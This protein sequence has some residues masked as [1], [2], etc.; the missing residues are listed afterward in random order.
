M[1][2]I[3][4]LL[5]NLF[6]VNSLP[7]TNKI[8]N[9][10]NDTILINKKNINNAEG[11]ISI[12]KSQI[13]N[14]AYER[15]NI[16]NKI[17]YLDQTISIIIKQNNK[18]NESITNTTTEIQLITNNLN[19]ASI[20]QKS[21]QNTVQLHESKIDNINKNINIS[22]LNTISIRLN[23]VEA[24]ITD[25]KKNKNS[26]DKELLKTANDFLSKKYDN[27]FTAI[28]QQLFNI[29]NIFI[30]ISNRLEKIDN[31]IHVN[32]EPSDDK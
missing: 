28:E 17:T 19:T 1:K 6:L 7:Q 27:K 5:A 13:S 8:G 29:S 20:K 4:F 25:I 10:F 12:I 24:N 21:L 3:L 32:L 22:N 31:Y 11:N 9:K 2:I 23:N 30:K 15:S 14:E 18:I 26:Y 16:V